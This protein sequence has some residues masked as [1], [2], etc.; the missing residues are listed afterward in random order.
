M[1]PAE[2]QIK[3]LWEWCGLREEVIDEL[4]SLWHY[5]D[6]SHEID[7]PYP[8]LNNLFEWA[9]PKLSSEATFDRVEI[10]LPTSKTEFGVKLVARHQ[11]IVE[12]DED[13]ALALFWAIW[14]VIHV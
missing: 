10:S 12:R 14:K 8:D 6:G 11:T 7:M 9:V 2:E 1:Q 4:H 3:E 5:P 13:P